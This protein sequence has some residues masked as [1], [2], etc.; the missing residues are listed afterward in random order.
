MPQLRLSR[1]ELADLIAY[2]KAMRGRGET[3]AS[4][5]TTPS[6]RLARR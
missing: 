2:F 1:A 6:V 5:A 4:L 3:E